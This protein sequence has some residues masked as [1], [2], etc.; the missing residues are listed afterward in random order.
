MSNKSIVYWAPP[1]EVPALNNTRENMVTNNLV[2]T[3]LVLDKL[4]DNIK[5]GDKV[6]IKVHVGE[7]LNTRYLRH[8]YV[9]EVVDAIKSKGGIPT[10]IETQGIGNRMNCIEI[11]EDYKVCVGHRKNEEDHLK[12]AHLHGYTEDIIGAPLKFVDG[13]DGFQYKKVIIDGIQLKDV[14]VASGLF[15]FD[16]MVVISRFKGHAQCAFGGALKQLGIGCMSKIGKWFAHFEGSVSVNIKK[17]DISKCNQEC[18][19]AC[20][21]NSIEIKEDKAHIDEFK[22]MGCFYCVRKCPVKRVLTKPYV[23]EGIDFV[24]R[25]TDNAAAVTQSFGAENIRYISFATEITFQCDCVSN[26]GMPV[27]PDLGI[28][29][30]SDPVALDKACVDA[31]TEA[32]GLAFRNVK[33][34]WIDPVP[35]GIEKF[36]ALGAMG[37]ASWILEAAVQN[38]IGSMEYE[39]VSI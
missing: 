39:L 7:A 31:E 22:C 28:F 36:K 4:L 27:I 34:E 16:K 29:A 20:P 12:I 30:S 5:S 13:T 38:K 14:A 8:D 24:K 18:I 32:P 6:A 2:K 25:V 21:L 1:F 33:G 11:S 15:K 19:A 37:D 23:N 17:C 26:I 10:L 3:K 9:R 35:R